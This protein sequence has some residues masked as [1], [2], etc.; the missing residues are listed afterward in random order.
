MISSR[1]FDDMRLPDPSPFPPFG[2]PVRGGADFPRAALRH[3]NEVGSTLPSL[4]FTPSC[5]NVSPL[6]PPLLFFA[7]SPRRAKAANFS[8]FG[9]AR[10]A[11]AS[12]FLFFF[13]FYPLCQRN[14]QIPWFFLSLGLFA[15]RGLVTSQ[16]PR[17]PILATK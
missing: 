6:L 12:R 17:L 16:G 9:G 10:P 7:P 15:R 1:Q 13:F 11:S 4:S 14:H 8:S 3:L 2:P 5:T